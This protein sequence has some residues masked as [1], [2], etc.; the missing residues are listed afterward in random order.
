M[1]WSIT[2]GRVAGTAVRIHITFLMLL[3]WIGTSAYMRGGSDAAL[4]NVVFIVLLFSCVLLHEFGHIFAARHFGIPTPEVTLLPIGGVAMLQKL[5]DRPMEQLLVAVAGPAVNVVIA[6]VLFAFMGAST[7]SSTM[8][9][10]LARIDDPSIGMVAKLAAANVFLVVFNMIPAFPMDGGRVLNALLA[11]RLG[12]RAAIRISA[13]IG[14]ALAILFGFL[15]HFG[16]PLL[17]F[18]AIFV[19]MAAAGEAA[20]SE[21]EDVTSDLTVA[22][23]M[24]TKFAALGADATLEDAVQTL[25]A[26]PQVEFPV[27]DSLRKPMGVLTR[28]GLLAA[29]G[30]MPRDTNVMEA[31]QSPAPSMRP[32]DPLA[33]GLEQLNQSG[34]AAMVVTGADGT[35][36]G[37]LTRQNISEMM[38]I[39]A[40]KPE[41][42][43][44]RA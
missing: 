23:A 32:G 1:S 6:I 38:M 8:A 3:V 42:R 44:R 10:G 34:A 37:M 12:K 30:T 43:F 35:A 13:R 41:W 7:D 24:E 16:N 28:D 40:V 2:L 18:I 14:Q 15:G 9:Q 21:I 25:L 5:P 26:T 20:A 27:L 33:K 29:L 4:N 19:Y 36:L 22:D 17:I 39:R 31:V 11:M